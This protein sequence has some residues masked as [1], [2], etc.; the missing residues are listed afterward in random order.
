MSAELEEERELLEQLTQIQNK[1]SSLEERKKKAATA[2][3]EQLAKQ[4]NALIVEGKRKASAAGLYF[5]YSDGYQ[6]FGVYQWEQSS[7]C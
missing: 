4:I 3:L 2:E 6:E 7:Y 1:L 5:E